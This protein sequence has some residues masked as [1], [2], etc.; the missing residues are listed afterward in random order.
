MRRNLGAAIRAA[1][2]SALLLGPPAAAATPT[3]DWKIEP[4]EARCVAVRQ[5]SDGEKPISLALKAPP[6]GTAMQLAV[7]RQAYRKKSEQTGAT[8]EIDGKPF[9]T[10]ALG[11]PLGFPAK[12]SKQ[13][14]SLI[15]LPQD[16]AVAMRSAKHVDLKVK[17]SFQDSFRLGDPTRIWTMMD[18][19]LERLRQTW[20]IGIHAANLATV[21]RATVPF[22]GM[23]S[24]EDFPLQVIRNV[25][26]GKVTFLLMIDETG[27]V[28]D[29]TLAESSG[30]AVID[31][32]SCA[33][34]TY[35]ARFEPATGRDGKPAKSVYEQSITWRV[36]D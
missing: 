13:S 32:R 35:K 8:I 29:C 6:T 27:K 25:W 23:F 36:T 18:S 28:K 16:A 17:S 30:I 14:V 5:Y 12:S 34:V 7:I 24:P 20:N 2:L 21:A 15:H 10:Y 33:V 19:C 9:T 22:D 26:N 31:S 4:A 1:A 3:G 11:Y